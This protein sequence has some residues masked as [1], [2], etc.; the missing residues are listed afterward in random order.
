MKFRRYGNIVSFVFGLL[1]SIQIPSPTYKCIGGYIF[2]KSIST[3][4]ISNASTKLFM[5][6]F[7]SKLRVRPSASNI[8]VVIVDPDVIN[9]R[10]AKPIGANTTKHAGPR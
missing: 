10:I 5:I 8:N 9:S 4:M 3:N 7:P 6:T 1:Y 2:E